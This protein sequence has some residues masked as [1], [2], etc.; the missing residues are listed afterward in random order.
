[1]APQVGV[2]NEQSIKGS[3]PAAFVVSYIQWNY[4]PLTMQML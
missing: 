3:F 2:I 4:N 1:M